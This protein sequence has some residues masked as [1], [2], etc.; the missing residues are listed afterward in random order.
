[1]KNEHRAPRHRLGNRPNPACQATT[2]D[3]HRP[4]GNRQQSSSNRFSCTHRARQLPPHHRTHTRPGRVSG[5]TEPRSTATRP[6]GA[7]PGSVDSLPARIRSGWKD[8]HH[9]GG[10]T[11][12]QST[13]TSLDQLDALARRELSAPKT[14]TSSSSPTSK[15]RGT[16]APGELHRP[17]HRR[18]L[19]RPA[20]PPPLRPPHPARRP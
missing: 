13:I 16:P 10:G 1:M 19:R 8:H 3:P 5:R 15:P 2:T 20:W 9:A 6:R 7:A 12:P 14:S 17:R 4:T 11:V 18:R